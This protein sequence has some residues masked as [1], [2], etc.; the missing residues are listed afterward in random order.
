M[1]RINFLAAILVAGIAGAFMFA[2]TAQADTMTHYV[3]GQT[4]QALTLTS[5]GNGT[6]D[7]ALGTG[8]PYTL[9]G[10]GIISEAG[11]ADELSTFSIST[12]GTG[13]FG[14]NNGSGVFYVTSP[15]TSTLAITDT[16]D[17]D[18]G[19]T[20]TVNWSFFRDGTNYPGLFG[21]VSFNGVNYIIDL[22]LNN[23]G[24]HLDSFALTSQGTTTSA[25]IS[26][27]E[28]DM[29]PEPMSMLLMMF[30]FAMI[31][32]VAIRRRPVLANRLA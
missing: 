11:E 1:R 20:A 4:S 9:S 31:G 28:L 17:G 21:T 13:T 18:A 26:S 15:F 29:A 25:V 19:G 5:N 10:S 32:L 14:P 8:T 27:G 23:I 6:F 12:T 7:V 3:F 22:T 2:S 30:G 16:S 24:Q